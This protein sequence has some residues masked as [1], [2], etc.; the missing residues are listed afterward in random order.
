M[1][2]SILALTAILLLAPLA[3]RPASAD[4]SAVRWRE[5]SDAVFEQ[6]ARENK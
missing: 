2:R 4:D 3:P 5:F 1:R 6:A